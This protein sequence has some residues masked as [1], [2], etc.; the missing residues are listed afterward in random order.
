[1]VYIVLHKDILTNIFI[2][3]KNGEFMNYQEKQDLLIDSFMKLDES[4]KDH[5]R[6]LTRK[7]AEIHFETEFQGNFGEKRPVQ[8]KKLAN[9]TV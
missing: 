6:E 7:L 8:G 3:K 1:M 9:N 4:N 2:L 5:I